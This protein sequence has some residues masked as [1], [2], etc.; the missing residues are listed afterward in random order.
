LVAHGIDFEIE[1][2]DTVFDDR[3]QIAQIDEI[4]L[5]FAAAT[6][7]V[8]GLDVIIKEAITAVRVIQ[9][10]AVNRTV[11]VGIHLVHLATFS[12]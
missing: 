12:R 1:T 2:A 10:D 7:V 8:G 9:I 11:D 4:V 6:A 3:V 5:V